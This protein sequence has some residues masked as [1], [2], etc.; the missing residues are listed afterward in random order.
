[1][2]LVLP[3][4]LSFPTWAIASLGAVGG[5]WLIA[6]AGFGWRPLYEAMG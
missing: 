4:Y 6:A 3:A 5:M 2:L 1:M